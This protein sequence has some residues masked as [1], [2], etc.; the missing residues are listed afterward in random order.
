MLKWLPLSLAL[1]GCAVT[2][3][4]VHPYDSAIHWSNGGAYVLKG[5]A[6]LQQDLVEALKVGFPR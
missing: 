1:T 2:T 3:V 5:I 4:V 6:S